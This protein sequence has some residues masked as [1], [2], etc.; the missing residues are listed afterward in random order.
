MMNSLR[1]VF[2]ILLFLIS[3]RG[4]N[5]DNFLYHQIQAVILVTDPDQAADLITQWSESIRGYYL[6][7][8]SDH[9]V[10]RF[11]YT[12]IGALRTFLENLSED[13]IE[14]SP[15]AFDLREEI[16]G[17]QSGISSREEILKKNLSFINSA[18][19]SGTLAIEKEI[20]LLLEEIENLKGRLRKLTVDRSF[21][22]AD[23]HLSFMEQSL[24]EDIPSSFEWINS[25]NFYSFMQGG[26]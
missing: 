4:L 6:L 11:P 24:P 16:L 2:M 12:E 14:I 23:I 17:I 8:S 1:A 15:E 25:V 9:V 10:I 21:A 26:F 19:V 18:D 13:V 7:K 20:I 22:R 3:S 5:A